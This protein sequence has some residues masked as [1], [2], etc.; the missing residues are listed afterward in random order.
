M[1]SNASVTPFNPAMMGPAATSMA[2]DTAM[3]P[4]FT[5]HPNATPSAGIGPGSGAGSADT[6]PISG[7]G[8]A[9][10]RGATTE[11]SE[12]ANPCARRAFSAVS[13]LA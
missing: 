9:A 7:A 12:V 11:M 10:S 13:A 3:A 5:N 8:V 1:P 6:A 2:P 4:M